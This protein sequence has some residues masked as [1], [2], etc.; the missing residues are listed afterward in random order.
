MPYFH[1]YSNVDYDDYQ[2]AKY[3]IYQLERLCHR[4]KRLVNRLGYVYSSS[5]TDMDLET[6]THVLCV[7]LL[8]DCNDKELQ[9]VSESGDI[10]YISLMDENHQKLT[11]EEIRNIIL[12]DV[13]RRLQE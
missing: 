2:S 7:S 8:L 12:N 9:I 13:A 10:S 4:I 5:T 1:V 6:D 11:L 3:D